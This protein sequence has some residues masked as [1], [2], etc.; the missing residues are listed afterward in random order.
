MKIRKPHFVGREHFLQK[1]SNK[2]IT[3]TSRRNIILTLAL[4]KLTPKHTYKWIVVYFN[5][6]LT[7]VSLQNNRWIGLL[8]CPFYTNNIYLAVPDHFY[9]WLV[10]SNKKA[11]ILK[12]LNNPL[13]TKHRHKARAKLKNLK[14]SRDWLLQNRFLL[15]S[16]AMNGLYLDATESLSVW[17]ACCRVLRFVN[18]HKLFNIYIYI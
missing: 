17:L 15:I 16:I 12:A 8:Q 9:L 1:E 14:F 7:A 13:K 4:N 6:L 5:V 11:Q 18:L 10:S 2:A 3:K